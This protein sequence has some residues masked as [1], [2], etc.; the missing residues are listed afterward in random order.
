VLIVDDNAA[1]LEGLAEFF[2]YEG[3]GTTAEHYLPQSNVA[4][5][6]GLAADATSRKRR[7][8]LQTRIAVACSGSGAGPKPP[9]HG[10]PPTAEVHASS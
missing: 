9:A 1:L 7:P 8:S 5:R 3:Y 4:A 10:G 2:E 6:Q